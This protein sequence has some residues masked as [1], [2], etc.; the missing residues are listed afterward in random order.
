MKKTSIYKLICMLLVICLAISVNNTFVNA[1][2]NNNSQN[3]AST[4]SG[5]K[6]ITYT[7]KETDMKNYCN[8]GRE[9]FKHALRKKLPDGVNYE[10]S[11]VDKQITFTLII[12]F[13]NFDEYYE[14]HKKMLGDEIN[15]KY[16]AGDNFS[17]WESFDN[18]AI[19]TYLDTMLKEES[20]C[21]EKDFS[22]FATYV[23]TV[24]NINDV[25]YECNDVVDIKGD[26]IAGILYEYISINLER[27][28]DDVL[29]TVHARVAERGHTEDQYGE[30]KYLMSKNEKITCEEKDGKFYMEFQVRTHSLDEALSEVGTLLGVY[31]GVERTYEYVDMATVAV[32]EKINILYEQI[33]VEKGE[34]K[35]ESNLIGW[36]R[37][38]ASSNENIKIEDY[39]LSAN[40]IPNIEY[41]YHRD[42]KME[43]LNITTDFSDKW[44]KYKR[45][46]AYQLPM[47]LALPYNEAIVKYMKSNLVDGMNCE[48]SDIVID[49]IKY[50]NYEITMVSADSKDIEKF[51]EKFLGAKNQF[52]I[53]DGFALFGKH[54]LT[55]V[56]KVDDQLLGMSGVEN[57]VIKYKIGDKE[58]VADSKGVLDK[59][60]ELSF[61]YR[62]VKTQTWM[63]LGIVVL[64]IIIIAV[65]IWVLIRKIK[66]IIA[67]HKVAQ[68]EPVNQILISE[69]TLEMVSEEVVEAVDMT[70]CPDEMEGSE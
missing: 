49:D 8:S 42:M 27:R 2:D 65:Y 54:S 9:G 32:V 28:K 14:I 67:K 44:G 37:G 38:L 30:F 18:T 10:I 66:S 64:V 12:S 6:E 59:Y 35:Y 47:E 57:V 13:N 53:D 16:G 69:E 5:T 11:Q 17:L 3:E 43:N 19:T 4:F 50:R 20:I 33:M 29:T 31:I 7:I 26:N 34:M 41:T 45:T 21:I 25:E 51:T 58:V 61:E 24:L 52:I 63:V 40:N 22:W 46:I 48:V 56:I 62:L 36:H 60:Q 15:I 55:D 39:R 70:V 23:G 68:E 1:E